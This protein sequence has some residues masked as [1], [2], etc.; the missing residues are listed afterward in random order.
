MKG[1][2]IFLA[3]GFE[4]V[5]ALGTNDVLSRGGVRTKLVAI[6]DDPFVV[7]SHGITVGVDN[8][9]S[10]M[11]TDGKGTTL[12]DV[13]IFPGGMPGALNLKKSAVVDK[14][15]KSA[16]END[17]LI[18][19]I[20]AAPGVVLS[21]TG[22]LCGKNYTCFPGFETDEGKYTSA[23]V[24]H[25]GKLITANGPGAATEFAIEIAAAFCENE[26]VKSLLQK[27]LMS[28]K[29]LNHKWKN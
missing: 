20:C 10:D 24:E 6:S 25:D 1:V 2:N 12:K 18:G 29:C 26:I 28:L 16:L 4:D 15:I 9:L 13:M 21:G 11:D 27:N 7:S 5:E 8:F 3:D 22:A 14:A 17:I 19:A 23:K